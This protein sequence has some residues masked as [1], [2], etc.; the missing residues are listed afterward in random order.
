[1]MDLF[2]AYCERLEIVNGQYH[3]VKGTGIPKGCSISPLLGAIYL[4]EVDGL[5]KAH[6]VKYVRYMDDLLFVSDKRWR[7]K[8]VIGKVLEMVTQ[9]KQRLSKEKTAIGRARKGFDWLGFRFDV[10][11]VKVALKTIL[12]H[13]N[14][15][16]R[17]LERG[18]S[19]RRIEQYGQ[20]W[21]R[22]CEVVLRESMLAK[23]ERISA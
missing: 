9:L 15:K 11:P 3:L 4:S 16:A 19:K 6:R 5:G 21:L 2:R 18:V 12:N 10:V 8:R 14:R 20:R 22:W 17:L 23:S 1:M 13:L 7:I